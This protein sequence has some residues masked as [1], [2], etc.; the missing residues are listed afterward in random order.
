MLTNL[1]NS[2]NDATRKLALE[3]GLK[4]TMTAEND[5]QMHAPVVHI[6]DR[7]RFAAI[8]HGMEYHNL[9]AV[10]YIHRLVY[11]KPKRW[12]QRLFK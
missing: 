2:P 7:G 4:F 8:L 6:I 11:G 9:N 3:Y 12:W 1:A 10:L 5:K